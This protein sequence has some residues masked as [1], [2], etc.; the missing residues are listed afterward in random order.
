MWIVELALRRPHTFIVMAVLIVMFGALS[1]V[2]MA[3]DIFPVIDIP[4][5][6]CIWTYTGMSPYEMENMITTVTE[7][8]L[9]STINGIQRMESMSLSGMSIVKVYLRQ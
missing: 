1:V 7:R 9:T 2:R 4:V 5:V 8:A 3:V 6:S